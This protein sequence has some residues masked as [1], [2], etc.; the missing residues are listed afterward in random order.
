MK[1]IS[2][3][4]ETEI[5]K[6]LEDDGD[7][8]LWDERKRGN[9]PKHAKP[10]PPEYAKHKSSMGASVRMPL[11]MVKDLKKIAESDGLPYQTLIKHILTK[12]LRER[13]KNDAA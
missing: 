1:K 11:K 7:E 6:M 3:K 12:Y 5:E 4:R 10:A 8:S 13:G 2:K 9:D